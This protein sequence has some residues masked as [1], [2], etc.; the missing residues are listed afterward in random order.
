EADIGAFRLSRLDASVM[1]E[2]FQ[3][4]TES[5][6][7]LTGL[8]GNDWPQNL[9][10]ERNLTDLHWH[11]RE[12][13]VRR[14]FSWVIRDLTGS[15]LGCAYLL[16]DPGERGM[17]QVFTWVRDMPDRVA[18]NRAFDAELASW[19]ADLLPGDLTLRWKRPD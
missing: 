1:D 9:T 8:F 17:A 7:V 11:D 19:F 6:A 2:D 5:T 4:V 16:P 14:S 12:F 15:Y 3:A 18:I 10:A 13:T